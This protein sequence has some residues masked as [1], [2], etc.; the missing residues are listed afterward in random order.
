MAH[1][2]ITP[3]TKGADGHKDFRAGLT[4]CTGC[5]IIADFDG[6]IEIDEE[7]VVFILGEHNVT[8]QYIAVEN[9]SLKERLMPEQ[10][11]RILR[12]LI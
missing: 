10:V 2:T 7:T 3:A 5:V 6:Q 1:E 8:D 12:N 9:A 11:N 4:W